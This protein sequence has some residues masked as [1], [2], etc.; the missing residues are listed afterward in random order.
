M[1][2]AKDA[3]TTGAWATLVGTVFAHRLF[4]LIPAIG[5]SLWVPPTAKIPELGDVRA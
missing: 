5:L 4:D 2:D 1:L 3:E